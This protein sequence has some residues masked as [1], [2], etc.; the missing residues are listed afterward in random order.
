MLRDGGVYADIDTKCR[1]PVDDWVPPEF[2]DHVGLVVGIEF[3]GRGESRWADWTRDLQFASWAMLAKPGHLAL[4]IATNKAM[5]GIKQLAQQHGTTVADLKPSFGDILDTTG[6]SMFTDAV[7]ESLSILTGTTFTWQ[8]ITGLEA[9][10]LVADVLI[11][12]ING[13]GSGQQHSKSGS[14]EG[15]EVLVEHLFKGSWKTD[16][17]LNPNNNHADGN[18][19]TQRDTTSTANSA[20]QQQSDSSSRQSDKTQQTISNEDIAAQDMKT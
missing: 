11:L 3:D 1:V 5:R 8:N 16:H 9:P 17:P 14:P 15:E 7:L 18:E 19:E 20:E 12:P 2:R 13:F 4:E 10:R 6:P